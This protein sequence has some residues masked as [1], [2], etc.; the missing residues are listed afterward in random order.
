VALSIPADIL[1]DAAQLLQSLQDAAEN[2]PPWLA[3]MAVGL[4]MVG[5]FRD[6]RLLLDNWKR[7]WMVSGQAGTLQAEPAPSAGRA[8]L[9]L[10]VDYAG[11]SPD[12]ARQAADEMVNLVRRTRLCSFPVYL[13]DRRLEAGRS[14]DRPVL[15]KEIRE[16]YLASV[17]MPADGRI[18]REPGPSSDEGLSEEEAWTTFTPQDGTPTACH[19]DLRCYLEPAGSPPMAGFGFVR[20]PLKLL[21]YRHG[22]LCGQQEFPNHLS[23][24]E[25]TAHL[26]GSHYPC[27]LSGLSLIP[28]ELMF[29]KQL[30]PL[31]S[32]SKV[33][34]VLRSEL[35]RY[36][37]VEPGS[38]VGRAAMGAVAAPLLV[39]LLGAVAVPVVL[40]SSLAAG[41]AAL[42]G[43]AGYL[44]SDR[45][46]EALRDACL[47]AIT[48]YKL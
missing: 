5:E 15:S 44:N 14:V 25:V 17:S 1:P 30:K 26:D 7:A 20:Q 32:L 12:R 33:L 39:L 38:P 36:R 43:V 31:G 45:Q 8:C 19:L 42:G 34:P 40:K 10:E 27:D 41:A 2:V 6:F 37:P 29:P 35:E 46:E 18:R 9:T 21:W 22:V 23:S 16:V 11:K 13:D 24:L 47:K 4:K 3:E 28:S 48:A